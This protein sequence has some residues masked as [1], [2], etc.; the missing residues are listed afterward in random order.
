[1]KSWRQ[2]R[3]QPAEP[4]TKKDSPAEIVLYQD[5]ETST[6]A[7]PLFYT[8]HAGIKCYDVLLEPLIWREYDMILYKTIKTFQKEQ[9]SELFL[10]VNWESGKYPDKIVNGLKNS[11]VVI[12]AWDGEKLVGLIRG[13]DDGETVGFIHYL[14]VN[15]QYQGQHIGSGLMSRLMEEYKNLLYIKIMP[16]D[17]KTIPF[18]KKF[19]FEIFDN[20]SA[21]EVKRL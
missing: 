13:L 10:S 21:M 20:Y 2:K 16:S 7:Q 4:F 14:L 17:P 3:E 8:V 18:Y 19:G 6:V 12:S 11:S 1:M 9:I 15:P 5:L